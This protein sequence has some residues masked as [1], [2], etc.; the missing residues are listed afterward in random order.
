MTMLTKPIPI[1]R[2]KIDIHDIEQVKAWTKNLNIS[3]DELRKLIG[4]VG[5]SA[6]AVRR[7]L[8]RRDVADN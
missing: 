6:A 5:N 4:T 3:P 1:D 8:A 7:E 2:S